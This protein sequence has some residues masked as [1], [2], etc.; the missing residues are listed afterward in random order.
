MRCR[1]MMMAM[2]L[3]VMGACEEGGRAEADAQPGPGEVPAT[4]GME[5]TVPPGPAATDAAAVVPAGDAGPV[6]SAPLLRGVAGTG[7][8]Q[9]RLGSELPPY[10][11]D[12][13]ELLPQAHQRWQQAV[14]AA[15]VAAPPWVVSLKGT[16]APLRRVTLGGQPMVTGWIC[17]PHDCGGNELVLLFSEDQARI[18]GLLRLTDDRGQATEKPI[19]TDRADEIRCARFFMDD[20]TD[21]AA[22]RG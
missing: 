4:S 7:S 19:G 14:Q 22:C 2:G 10:T 3:L 18:F 21:A 9:A 20:R 11:Y 1:A 5:V 12:I 6:S 16:A 17:Q 8:W 13:P 15:G